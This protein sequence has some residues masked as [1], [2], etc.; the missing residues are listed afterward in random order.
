M[1]L[2]ASMCLA[3]CIVVGIN[4]K[5]YTIA[6]IRLFKRPSSV[7]QREQALALCRQA[8]IDPHTACG[9]DENHR[10]QRVLSDYRLIVL[11]SK[12]LSSLVF[13]G[14]LGTPEKPRTNLYLLWANNH[15]YSI[16]NIAPLFAGTYSCSQCLKVWKNI[17]VHIDASWPAGV[18]PHRKSVS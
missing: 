3:R 1:I 13:I 15:F 10:M 5:T 7:E 14:P 9:M 2:C 4:H 8:N 18:A 16:L 17:Y 11:D 6:Q 12:D